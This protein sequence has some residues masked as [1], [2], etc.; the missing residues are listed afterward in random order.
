MPTLWDYIHIGRNHNND[1]TGRNLQEGLFQ[2]ASQTC[3]ILVQVNNTNNISYGN[4][5]T[6]IQYNHYSS[7]CGPSGTQASGGPSTSSSSSSYTG[8]TR[9]NTS[10]VKP[11]TSVDY[12]QS[13]ILLPNSTDNRIIS[14]DGKRLNRTASGRKIFS[15]YRHRLSVS[16]KNIIFIIHSIVHFFL[17]MFEYEYY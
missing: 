5:A 17:N 15:H 11:S 7:S 3:N 14:A 2:I 6:N 4:N 16:I 8:T 1:S 12:E 10:N 9:K 13:V